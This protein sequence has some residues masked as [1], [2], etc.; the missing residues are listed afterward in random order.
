MV[1]SAGG[2][3]ARPSVS[4]RAS[5]NRSIGFLIQLASAHR[6][7]RGPSRSAR[8]PSAC[9]S[10]RPGRSISSGARSDAAVSFLPDL[11]GGITSSGSLL[12]TRCDQLALAALARHDHGVLRPQ[13]AFLEVEP[14]VGLARLGVRPV[15][16][17]AV[18]R[19][20]GRMS[21]LKSTGPAALA[22]A[23]AGRNGKMIAAQAS[24]LTIRPDGTRGG[25][26]Q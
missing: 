21:R 20:I 18:L 19:R 16:G 8:R 14:Q 23:A 1:R 15:A 11:G 4:S 3:G 13:R 26:R 6:R 5:T 24:K 22:T 25:R 17:E 2:D 7:G 9:S 10:A 12:V